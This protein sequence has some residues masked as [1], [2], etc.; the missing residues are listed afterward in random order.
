[1]VAGGPPQVAG[2][3][4]TAPTDTADDT[5][6]TNAKRRKVAHSSTQPDPKSNSAQLASGKRAAS[7]ADATNGEEDLTTKSSKASTSSQPALERKKVSTKPANGR[8]ARPTAEAA[9]TKRIATISTS[10]KRKRVRVRKPAMLSPTDLQQDDE[11]DTHNAPPKKLQRTSPES[12]KENRQRKAN[13]SND[14]DSL[15]PVVAA[16]QAPKKNEESRVASVRQNATSP[17]RQLAS[18]DKHEDVRDEPHAPKRDLPFLDE[19]LSDAEYKALEF[20]ASEAK[21]YLDQKDAV[22]SDWERKDDDGWVTMKRVRLDKLGKTDAQK[23]AMAR[24]ENK[25]REIVTV[26]NEHAIARKRRDAAEAATANARAH[27]SSDEK[28]PA[29]TQTASRSYRPR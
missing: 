7:R 12:D 3:K 20:S 17:R 6:V 16:N 26:Y 22:G 19:N 8:P 28:K 29:S 11:N 18:A 2:H 4:R 5:E 25:L 10:S 9:T 15:S 27:T 1:M 14:V 21:K 23:K 13:V 24:K